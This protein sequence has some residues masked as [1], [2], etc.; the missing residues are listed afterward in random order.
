M[1]VDRFEDLDCWKAARELVALVYKITREE[2][3]C[4]DFGLRDQI[5]RASISTMANVAEGFATRSDLEFIRFLGI[6]TRSSFEV[7][8]H[9][10]AALDLGYVNKGAFDSACSKAQDCANLCR[11]LIKYIKNKG[12]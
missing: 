4:R 8:S 11:G 5:Q 7:R 2:P 9:L 10:Y 12:K 3:F 6:A 1:L